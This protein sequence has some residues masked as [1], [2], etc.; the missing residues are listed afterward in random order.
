M[1]RA[2]PD[3]ARMANLAPPSKPRAE[4]EQTRP[5]LEPPIPTGSR[6]AL[7]QAGPQLPGPWFSSPLGEISAPPPSTIS[8]HRHFAR[9]IQNTSPARTPP[10]RPAS[11]E[12]DS[13]VVPR[14]L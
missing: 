3:F 7:R 9:R 2:L 1:I 4:S 14:D 13:K 5:L 11:F 10:W 6:P 12:R 8:R